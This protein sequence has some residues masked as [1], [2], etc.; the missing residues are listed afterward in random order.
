MIFDFQDNC[1]GT[2]NPNQLD[3]IPITLPG[4]ACEH[5]IW[6]YP[7]VSSVGLGSVFHQNLSTVIIADSAV[8]IF[9]SDGSIDNR[10]DVENV[11]GL[12]VT[13]SRIKIW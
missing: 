1:P 6:N 12:D 4:D 10:Q 2:Y 5:S 9:R 7:F 3:S 8:Y 11:N 13:K